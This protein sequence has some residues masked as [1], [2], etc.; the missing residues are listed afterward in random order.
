MIQAWN[1]RWLTLPSQ[2]PMLCQVSQAWRVLAEDDGLW[3]KMCTGEGYHQNASMSDSPCWKSTLRDCRFSAKAVRTNWKVGVILF[4]SQQF[5]LL[6]LTV[7]TF[8]FRA[9]WDPSA[10]CSLSW[11]RYSAMSVPVTNLSWQGEFQYHLT[12]R[13]QYVWH[14]DISCKCIC[15]PC[16]LGL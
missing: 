7:T 5:F 9:E 15:L 11:G 8:V 2:Y 4:I 1:L 14:D 3:F 16:L 10:S 13:S 6:C 12:I